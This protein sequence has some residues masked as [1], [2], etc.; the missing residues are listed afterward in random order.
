MVLLN[1]IRQSLMDFSPGIAVLVGLHALR[2]RLARCNALRPIGPFA[3]VFNNHRSGEIVCS[4]KGVRIASIH[5][6]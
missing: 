4:F 2:D 1:N 5:H 3:L 6:F